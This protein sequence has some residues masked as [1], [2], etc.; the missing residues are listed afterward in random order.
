MK[1]ILIYCL[2]IFL[3]SCNL[4]TQENTVSQF[5]S[6]SVDSSVDNSVDNS[7][8]SSLDVPASSQEES[9][10]SS[11]FSSSSEDWISCEEL[12]NPNYLNDSSSEE[13][14]KDTPEDTN[15]INNEKDFDRYVEYL[16][17]SSDREETPIEDHIDNS[18]AHPLFICT[19]SEEKLDHLTNVCPESYNEDCETEGGSIQTEILQSFLDGIPIWGHACFPGFPDIGKKCSTIQECSYG[20]DLSPNTIKA[21]CSLHFSM[22]SDDSDGKAL[23]WR[24]SIYDCGAQSKPGV[25]KS[26]PDLA[27]IIGVLSEY[28]YKKGYVIKK[29]IGENII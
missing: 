3:F 29:D 13:Y 5:S 23:G 9:P 26:V 8:N 16:L 7:V 1:H 22:P 4:T 24:L 12:E 25:C 19:T 17:S 2:S 21:S 20:C 6:S 28:T 15:D 10:I 18:D 14:S 11:S 27:E